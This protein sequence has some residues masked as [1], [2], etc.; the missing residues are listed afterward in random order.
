VLGSQYEI[1]NACYF[2]T[3]SGWERYEI[4]AGAVAG[5]GDDYSAQGVAVVRILRMVERDGEPFV[6]LADTREYLTLSKEGPLHVPSYSGGD[7]HDDWMSLSTP[8][9][10]RW[11]MNPISGEF[12]QDFHSPPLARMDTG[13]RTQLAELGSFCW[14]GGCADGP[15]IST[16]SMPL[17]TQSPVVARLFLPLREPPDGLSLSAMFVSPLGAL[18]GDANY[19]YVGA[20]TASWSYEKPGRAAFDLGVFPLRREQEIKLSLEPGYYA[21]TVLAVWHDYGDVKYGFLIEVRE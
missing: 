12:F 6:E 9:G 19:D 5:S 21:L 8:L 20:D 15:V 2:D 4:Y 1:Q 10:F 3:Q 16:A 17:V 14:K 11:I 13:E 7:C 18:Q